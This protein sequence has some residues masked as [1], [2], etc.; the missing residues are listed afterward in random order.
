[1]QLT[2]VPAGVY[3]ATYAAGQ[4]SIYPSYSPMHHALPHT[5]GY[6]QLSGTLPAG[7]LLP[8]QV[9]VGPPNVAGGTAVPAAPVN[10]MQA[11][12]LNKPG[13]GGQQQT[14]L[15]ASGIGLPVT[16]LSPNSCLAGANSVSSSNSPVMMMTTMMMAPS[17]TTTGTGSGA[18]AVAAFQQVANLQQQQQLHP[19]IFGGQIADQLTPG[20]YPLVPSAAYSV[21]S[22]RPVGPRAYATAEG[23]IN[24]TTECFS[25]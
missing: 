12:G 8:R 7:S 18:A 3:P 14:L 16:S 20:T 9:M 10:I 22:Q 2:G 17:G 24:M 19:P 25:T 6:F 23:H 11:A 21:Q 5:T 1:M 15:R 13:S 4:P